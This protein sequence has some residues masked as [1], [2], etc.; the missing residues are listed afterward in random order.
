MDSKKVTSAAIF[1]DPGSDLTLIKDSLAQQL[2]LKP[3]REA[4]MTFE[5]ANA[6]CG[7]LVH[8]YVYEVQVHQDDGKLE[9]SEEEIAPEILLGVQYFWNFMKG[10][11]GAERGLTLVDS[12][13]GPMLCGRRLDASADTVPRPNGVVSLEEQFEDV[14]KAWKAEEIG[15][16][17]CPVRRKRDDVPGQRE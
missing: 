10:A 5:T 11:R 14:C 16:K 9:I 2:E 4:R 13:V 3:L 7:G 12:T 17:F 15:V 6:A 8:G 1:F